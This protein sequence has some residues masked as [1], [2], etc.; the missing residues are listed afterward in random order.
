MTAT[1]L[2]ESRPRL[3]I[4][5]FNRPEQLNAISSAMQRELV[6]ELDR[7][8]RDPDVVV[9]V[10]TGE[11][12]AF[13]AGAD[14]KE[15]AAFDAAA[16]RSFQE[17]G[18][19]VYER[20]ERNRKLVVSAVNGFALGGGF[21]MV[22]ASDLVVARRG[23]KLGLPEVTLGLVPGGGGTQRLGRKIG[24]N[25]A[26]ELLVQGTPRT[27]EELAAWGLVNHVTGNDVMSECEAWLAGLLER[28]V[29]AVLELKALARTA[30]E[31][32]LEAGLD[33]ERSV[34]QALF[35]SAEGQAR[36]SEFVK[37]HSKES[38]A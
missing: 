35:E 15:Y 23:A 31:S 38:G 4:L 34:L 13:M 12:R 26:L 8:E 2:V 9:I 10:L 32:P 30:Q 22:L 27:A 21:E 1:L 14:L 5:R 24:P 3:R 33:R 6:A 37:R 16:F 28:P 25:R 36:I 17:R 29:E 19:R 11:G 20:V 7:A 18:R